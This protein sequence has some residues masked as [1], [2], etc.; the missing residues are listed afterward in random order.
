MLCKEKGCN[1]HF[2]NVCDWNSHHR[3]QHR[4]VTFKCNLCHKVYNTPSSYKD[5]KYSHCPNQ[6]KCHQCQLTFPFKSDVSN[7]RRAHMNQHLFKCFSGGCRKA[8][9]HPQDLHRHIQTHMNITFTCNKCGHTTHQ[10]RLLKC[11]E[12]IHQNVYK[13]TCA[14]C[15]FKTKY[16]WSMMR[17]EKTC[18]GTK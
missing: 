8:Y 15:D 12:V 4:R 5:N 18:K 14:Y 17:H 1:K 16:A 11:N 9:K 2:S 13:C 3:L 7:H 6:F 10:K